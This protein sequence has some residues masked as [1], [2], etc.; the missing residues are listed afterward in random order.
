MTLRLNHLVGEPTAQSS[1]QVLHAL[2]VAHVA[3]TESEVEFSE[4]TV[5]VPRVNMN[6]RTFKTALQLREVVLAK[7]RAVRLV[8]CV[9]ACEV[10][11]RV[12]TGHFPTNRNVTTVRVGVKCCGSHFH[13]L[14]DYVTKRNGVHPRNDS[15]TDFVSLGVNQSD[16][17][18]LVRS[19]TT[20]HVVTLTGVSVGRVAT[21]VNLVSN[22]VANKQT[23]VVV[24][25]RFADTVQHVPSGPRAESVLA[26]N[27]TRGNAVLRRTHF[28]DHH[29]PRTNRNLGGVHHRAGQN[30]ELLAAGVATPHPTLGL[31]TASRGATRSVGGL[32][33]VN[34]SGRALRAHRRTVPTQVFKVQV[35]VGLGNNLSAQAGNGCLHSSTL[36]EG[37]DMPKAL[38][39]QL[40]VAMRK[41]SQEP[42]GQNHT[43]VSSLCITSERGSF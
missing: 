14:A 15:G 28:I 20:S 42:S 18:R 17:G 37:C 40:F 16:N 35:G 22:N 36:P 19:G 12:V 24:A 41:T 4:V 32:N 31:T 39:E 34:V 7:I 33:E 29:D 25:H 8:R 27:L 23:R 9:D 26:L 6:V 10:I 13:V 21:D 38:V 30:G 2:N 3:R 5:Q 11:D 43:A 1:T